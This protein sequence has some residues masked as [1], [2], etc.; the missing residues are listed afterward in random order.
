MDA[1]SLR[2]HAE[3]ILRAVIEDL[4][5]LQTPEQSSQKS[6]GR[7]APR[8][9]KTAAQTHALLRASSRFTIRQ[10]VAEYRALRA[11]V[12]ALWAEAHPQGPYTLEDTG[13][14]NEAI[15]QA[16][17]ESV[18]S[19]SAEVDR[20]RNVFLGV[21]SHDLRGP[22]NAIILT[23]HAIS[24]LGDGTPVSEP[25]A[26][27]IRSGHR[28]KELLDDLLDYN[29]SALELGMPVV[30]QTGNLATIC[31]EEIEVQ[32]TA[33]PG[34]TIEFSSIGSTEGMWDP[35]RV[36][37]LVANLVV[38]AAKYGEPAGVVTVRLQGCD[39][40]VRLAVENAGATIPAEELEALFEPLRRGSQREGD[41]TRTNLGLGLFIVREV[42]RAHGGT[43]RAESTH[44]RTT[45]TVTLPRATD[46][47]QA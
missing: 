37:Q 38:N 20:W 47:S 12:L 2:D 9:D 21:L 40:E 10:L 29:R 32:R 18:D 8:T 7:A 25:T 1:A 14:F 30:L 13:R 34:S 28:M 4:R 35:S 11:S 39:A 22:L 36:R 46:V 23:A 19:Y 24:Q 3:E 16:I 42:A 45:F 41:M 15:D 33:L 27:L 26:I 43:V 5:T 31:M 17:A 44:G 6:M